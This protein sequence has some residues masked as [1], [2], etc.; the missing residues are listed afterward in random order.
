M[1]YEETH[2][3]DTE[4]QVLSALAEGQPYVFLRGDFDGDTIKLALTCGGGVGSAEDIRTMLHL[5]LLQ[6]PED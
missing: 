6:L 4:T 3:E 1:S 2:Q 5:A